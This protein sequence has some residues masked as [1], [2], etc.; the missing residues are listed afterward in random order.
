MNQIVFIEILYTLFQ[1]THNGEHIG[2]RCLNN[3]KYKGLIIIL[4]DNDLCLPKPQAD[5]G[6]IT[7]GNGNIIYSLNNNVLY[8]LRRPVFPQDPED[9]ASFSF[10]EIPCTGISIL[11]SNS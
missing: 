11:L 6:H 7:N 9:I 10:I 1:S 5:P 3:L 8:F 2:P 4:S